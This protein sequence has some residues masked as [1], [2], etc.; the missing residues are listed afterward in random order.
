GLGVLAALFRVSSERNISTASDFARLFRPPSFRFG[1]LLSSFEFA[2][3]VFFFALFQ[4]LFQP[5]ARIQKFSLKRIEFHLAAFAPFL[6][7]NQSC[8]SIQEIVIPIR[9]FPFLGCFANSTVKAQPGSI[10]IEPSPQPRPAADQGLM[11]NI[12][13]TL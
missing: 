12:E 4:A 13:K 2:F 5:D 7:L 3:L 6:R 1:E 9:A 10:F 8:A 11:R